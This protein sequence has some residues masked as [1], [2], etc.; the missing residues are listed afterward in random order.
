M[1]AMETKRIKCPSCGVLLDVR[2]S[3]NEAVKMITCPQCKTQLRVM[4]SQQHA[5]TPQSFG[6]TEYVGNSNGETQYVNRDNGETRYV[7]HS[8]SPSQ[9]D[10]TILAGKNEEVT[11]GYL[12]YGGQKYSLGFGNNVIGR[13][14]TTSQ[15][16]VQIATDD[17]YM[18]R[19]HLVIQVI[20]ASTDKVR[21]VNST[22]TARPAGV[23][24]WR[25]KPWSTGATSSMAMTAI[26][27]ISSSRRTTTSATSTVPA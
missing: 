16:T 14:A 6:E 15:A 3:Q 13:K 8:S 17:R 7:G 27:A 10:E 22:S 24:R 23:P 25:D 11:P 12:L 18:S 21:V 26:A 5:A 20:K 1:V 4:F 19:Q 2:N 9:S